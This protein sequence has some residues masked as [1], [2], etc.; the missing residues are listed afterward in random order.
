MADTDRLDESH[1]LCAPSKTLTEE[2]GYKF[3]LYR[4]NRNSFFLVVK[5]P[6]SLGD[7]I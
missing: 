6:L 5:M 3:T 2:Y 1:I 4:V 7:V